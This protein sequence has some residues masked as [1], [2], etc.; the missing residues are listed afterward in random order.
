[1]FWY[2]FFVQQSTAYQLFIF[3]TFF[4]LWTICL[5]FVNEEIAYDFTE[6]WLR[7][8]S[9]KKVG[10]HTNVTAF[11][12]SYFA[13]QQT[14]KSIH[15]S[16]AICY[17]I[18]REMLVKI[19]IRFMKKRM[20]NSFHFLLRFYTDCVAPN[21]VWQSKCANVCNAILTPAWNWKRNKK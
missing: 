15:K 11:R 17:W 16:N 14:H 20:E 4:L 3:E 6:I 19:R 7:D 21:S 9:V 2:S 1:M 18:R 5:E 8:M 13:R 10:L 12:F